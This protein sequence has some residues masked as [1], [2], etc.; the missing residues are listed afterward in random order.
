MAQRVLIV[1]DDT[2]LSAMLADYL[3]GNGYTVHAAATAAA[4]LADLGRRMPDVVILDVMLPDL[5]GFE[6]CRR[7]RAVS[8]VPILMLTAKGEETDRIVGLELGADDYLPKPFN[9]RELLARLKAI[10]RRRN[11]SAA[12]SRVLR[13]GRLE[14]DPGSRSVRIDGDE[15]VLTS[16]QFDLLVA[17][18]E[19]AGRTL[20]RE[21]LMDTVKGEELDAFDRSIDVHISRIR[22]AIESD[23]KHPRRIITVRG[24]GYVF[25]RFQD[26]ER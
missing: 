4:G 18:A 21:R 10:L 22:A 17:L 16:Y 5:D 26:E 2:R 19:N 11:G 1:D 6:T 24:A 8:D 20:S 3:S 23:P 12:V 9:P 7:M 25:A 15:C 14:I 13:F